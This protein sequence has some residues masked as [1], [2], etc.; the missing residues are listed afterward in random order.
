VARQKKSPPVSTSEVLLWLLFAALIFPAAFAGYA[1]GHYTSLGK[2]P[3]TVTVNVGGTVTTPATT[4]APTTTTSA[5]TTTTTTTSSSGGNVAAGKVVFASSGCASCHTFKPAGA[6]GQV[7][8]NLDTAPTKDAA[9]DGNMNLAAFIKESIVNP[10][11]YIAK[12]Y[13]GGIM[14]PTFGTT[15]T[16]KQINDLVAFVLSGQQ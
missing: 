4:S 13:A 6:T 9:A 1:V 15:L 10:N 3:A 7:G 11:A 2:P 5:A 8:P 16:S 14:T 12:G